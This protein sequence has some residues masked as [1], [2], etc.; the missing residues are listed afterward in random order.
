M[1]I[2]LVTPYLP[3][4]RVG[5]GGGQAIRSQLRALAQRHDCL[6]VS[7]LRHGEQ[8]EVPA[9]AD[10]GFR[11]ATVPFLDARSQGVRRLQL[12]GVRL[13]AAARAAGDRYPYYV[14]KYH[15]PPLVRAVVE[16]AEA[17]QPDVIQVEYLQLAYLL[18]EL[19]RWRNAEPGDRRSATAGPRLVLSSHEA[20]SLPRRRRAA[21]ARWWRRHAL[22]AE[23]A[24]WD[25]LARD[26]SGWA[27]ATLCVTEQ[28]RRLLAAAG[29]QRLI[30]VPLGVDLETASAERTAALRRVLFV[31]SFQHP[32]NRSAAALLC[33]RIWPQVFAELPGWELVL[34]G[35]G[36]DRFLAERQ[37]APAGVTATGFVADLRGLLRQCRVLAAPLTEG[38]GIKI[39]ILEA[40]ACG[41]PVVTTAIGAEGIT[42]R[43]DE[44]VWWA[45]DPAE[46]AR[47]LL[48]AARDPA[49]AAARADRARR[50]VERYFSWT[51]VVERL[52]AVYRGDDPS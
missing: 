30:T 32:P 27:D 45:D 13:L 7:L 11:L 35:P 39:K 26:A 1:R 10:Q 37:P 2:L 12:I 49:T 44:L 41:L 5:H 28:D 17:F 15:W 25:R 14:A 43:A 24:A 16:A 6:C 33:D 8:T 50:H 19:R 52:E 40:M 18:R 4:P 38:G 20:S 9:A 23:A 48:A 46:F 36:S 42:T 29:G 3:H 21:E 47:Q 34:A 31:G 51:T 22:L